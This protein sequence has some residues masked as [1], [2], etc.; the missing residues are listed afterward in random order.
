[1]G[2]PAANSTQKVHIMNR[3]NWITVAVLALALLAV[4]QAPAQEVERARFHHVHL[5]V[6][7]PGR[8]IEFYTRVFGAVPIKFR[9]VADAVFTE[10]SFILFNKVDSP[11]K[12][13]QT[14]GIWHLG[15]GGV[16]V[17]NEA[18]WYKSQGVEVHT[19]LYP[20]GR[21]WVTYWND[22]DKVMIE[23]NTM[24][25][26]RYAHIH[27]MA[28]DVNAT[29]KWYGD[30]LGLGSRRNEQNNPRPVGS[31]AKYDTWKAFHEDGNRAWSNGVRIDNVSIAIYN[32]PDYEPAPPW[33]P[34]GPLK[35]FQPQRGRAID[36][37]AVSY[38][39]I[40]AV[41]DRMKAA[42]VEIVQAIQTNEEFNLKSFFVMAPNKV[43]VEIVEAKPI[44]EGLWD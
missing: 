34:F 38:R 10:R 1:M 26:H 6:T 17:P 16:D 11:A 36:H 37:F 39:D 20:L 8:S 32:I 23:V 22:P 40:D 31:G 15:W 28:K 33:W 4:R 9:G 43:V 35:D 19:E 30:H 14:T 18:K 13:D 25:H 21:S 3:G 29:A 27:L 41:F 12:G 7:D 5:N 2:R 44:P 24:G 42:G